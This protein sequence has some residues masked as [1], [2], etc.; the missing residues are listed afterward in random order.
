M[1]KTKNHCANEKVSAYFYNGFLIS[2]YSK[3]ILSH[4]EILSNSRKGKAI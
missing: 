2:E 3:E 4:L 1:Q